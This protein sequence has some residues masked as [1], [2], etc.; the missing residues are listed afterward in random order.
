MNLYAINDQIMR[1]FEAAV[2][3]DTGEVVNEEAYEALDS[4]QMEFSERAEGILLYI[5]N[6]RAESEA[7][8]KEKQAFESRQRAAEKKAE[9]LTKYIAGVL[10]GEKFKTERVSAT[11][12]KSET[13]E[14]VGD[15]MSLPDDCIRVKE[16]EIDKTELKKKLKSGVQIAG[17]YMIAK[18]NIQIK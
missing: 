17:A 4:L 14:Y 16:P 1:A 3:P 10:G 5:K 7:L 13:V 9:S 2:D 18:N 12:R 8:K 11:W 15:V 6:L